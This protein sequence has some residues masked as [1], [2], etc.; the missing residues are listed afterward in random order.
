[1]YRLLYL[2]SFSRRAA[3]GFQSPNGVQIAFEP[4]GEGRYDGM[5]F[6]SPNGVQIALNDLNSEIISFIVSITKR[7]TDCFSLAWIFFT[8]LSEFQSPNGVQIAFV[9]SC[10]LSL[11][12]ASFNHQTVYR[13]LSCTIM[14]SITLRAF[15]SPNGVQIAF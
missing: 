11:I 12:S 6:Q 13:L 7:C 8:P 15:Q 14:L 4:G 1:M 9:R 3:T 2:R 5:P 10:V